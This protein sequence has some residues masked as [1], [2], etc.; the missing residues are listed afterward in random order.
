MNNYLERQDG[1]VTH[2]RVAQEVVVPLSHLTEPVYVRGVAYTVHPNGGGYVAETAFVEDELH[3]PR[4]TTVGPRTNV[5]DDRC[6]FGQH[7]V[8][9]NFSNGGDASRAITQEE[10]E[11]LQKSRPDSMIERLLKR[12][13]RLLASK[14]LIDTTTLF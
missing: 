3:I 8:S 13:Q 9:G 4:E 14:A 11:S 2:V 1:V 5:L 7:F 12:E 6:I 10:L